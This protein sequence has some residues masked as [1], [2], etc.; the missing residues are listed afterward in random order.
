MC[1]TVPPTIET[2]AVKAARKRK[3]VKQQENALKKQQNVCKTVP[4]TIETVAVKAAGDKKCTKS[5]Q[6]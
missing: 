1:K 2:V 4:P 6:M 3:C 5:K